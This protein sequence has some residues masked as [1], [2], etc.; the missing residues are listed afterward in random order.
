MLR[1]SLAVAAGKAARV[2]SRLR[3]GGSALPGLVVERVD[4][5]FLAH[6]LADLARGLRQG[7]R[8]TDDLPPGRRVTLGYQG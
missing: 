8:L 7:P 3:G 1:T 2:A 6:A 4:P 5:A